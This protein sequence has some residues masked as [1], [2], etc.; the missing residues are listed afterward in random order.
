MEWKIT[1]A[2]VGEMMEEISDTI[3]ST[4]PEEL[5]MNVALIFEE[6]YVNVAVHGYAKKA[7]NVKPLRILWD[8]VGDDYKMTFIDEGI[9]FDP[10]TYDI[11][12]P[13]GDQVGGHGIRLMRELSKKMAYHKEGTE[14]ILEIWI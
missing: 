12:K 14:N 6:A 9:Y 2:E 10:T 7:D 13:K 5:Q 1:P 11:G 3:V 8:K 4:V